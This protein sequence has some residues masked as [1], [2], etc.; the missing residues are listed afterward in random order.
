MNCDGLPDLAVG[1]PLDDDGGSL[2][3]D[4]GGLWLV[5][6]GP[7]GLAIGEQLISDTAGGFTGI[8]NDAD[9]FGFAL[10]SLGDLDGDGK[11]DLA[12]GAPGDDDGGLNRG[13]LW[14]LAVDAGCF[15]GPGSEIVFADGFETGDTTAWDRTVL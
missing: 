4:R 7:T 3:A 9:N 6:L 10:A 11:L 13:A 2:D 1:V 5:P 15:P 14:N 8:L 12:A